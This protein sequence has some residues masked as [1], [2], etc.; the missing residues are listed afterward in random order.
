MP[1]QIR[2]QGHVDQAD[3]RRFVQH[4]ASEVGVIAA[5]NVAYALSGKSRVAPQ[6]T[7]RKPDPK[8][9]NRRQPVLLPEGLHPLLRPTLL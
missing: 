6:L 2:G 7:G 3:V 1:F 5:T 8:A 4:S 9:V